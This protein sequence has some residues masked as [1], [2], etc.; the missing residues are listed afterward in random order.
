M[1]KKSFSGPIL[2]AIAMLLGSVAAHAQTAVYAML[3]TSLDSKTA[4]VNDNVSA[5]LRQS[6][7]LPDGTKLSEGSLITGHVAAVKD[8]PGSITLVFDKAVDDDVTRDIHITILRLEE[9]PVNADDTNENPRDIGKSGTGVSKLHGLTL[10][11]GDGKETS[12]VISA[13]EK[14]VRLEYKTLL[15]CMISAS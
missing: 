11:A 1:T 10:Q 14:N 12:G 8:D 3:T 6:V 4:K 9:G 5:K 15:G 13:K 7:K 2:L